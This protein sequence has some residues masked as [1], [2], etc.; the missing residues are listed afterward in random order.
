MKGLHQFQV[1][2]IQ[3]FLK[4]KTLVV[5]SV[6][7]LTEYGANTVI[8]QKVECAIVRDDTVYATSKDGAKISNIYEKVVIK[9]KHPYSVNVA[10]GDE[11]ILVNATASVYGEFSNKLSITAE[12]LE[13]V[14]QKTR[15]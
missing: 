12:G 10:I 3:R 6:K 15:S 5:V 8:G 13:V 1:F 14:K 9:V 4:D 2:D 11:I 7:D